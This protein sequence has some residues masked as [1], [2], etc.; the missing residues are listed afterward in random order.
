MPDY[1][2]MIGEI[3]G[4]LGSLE[5]QFTRLLNQHDETRKEL[6]SACQNINIAMRQLDSI[7]K[8]LRLS[9]ERITKSYGRGE[10]LFIRVAVA[11][12]LILYSD[13]VTGAHGAIAKLF[14]SG[15]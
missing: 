6:S 7:E 10:R 14:G 2:E 5:S 4:R 15:K 12:L 11:V 13:S 8:A 1:A 9:N 3:K